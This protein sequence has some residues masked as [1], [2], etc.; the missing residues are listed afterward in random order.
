MFGN[1]KDDDER[2]WNF[3]MFKIP[4]TDKEIEEGVSPILGGI[5]LLGIVVLIIWAL[6][7]LC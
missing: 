6:I 7:K 5:F 4:M 2:F 1:K 3:I